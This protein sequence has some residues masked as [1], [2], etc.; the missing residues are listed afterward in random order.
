MV[1]RNARSYDFGKMTRRDA[2]SGGETEERRGS[3]EHRSLGRERRSSVGHSRRRTFPGRTK[4]YG[5]RR[6][7]RH[8][9]A[10]SSRTHGPGSGARTR[11]GALGRGGGRAARY[12]TAA[13]GTDGHAEVTVG[14]TL[15]AG[16][17]GTTSYRHGVQ[18]GQV[19]QLEVVT[20]TGERVLCSRTRNADLFDA[21]RAVAKDSSALLPRPGFGLRKAGRRIRQYELRYRDFDRFARDFERDHRR[22]PIRSS[23]GGNPGPR[24]GYPI[25]GAG[26]EYDDGDCED[27]EDARRVGVRRDRIHQGHG[28]RLDA[29]GSIQDGHSVGGCITPGGTGSCPGTPFERYVAQAWLDPRLGPASTGHLDRDLPD[30]NPGDRRPAL[31]ASEGRT[32]VLLLDPRSVRWPVR[33]RQTNWRED[34][35]KIDRTLVDLGAKGLSVR[36]RGLRTEGMGGTLRRRSF[37]MG[38]GWKKGV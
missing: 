14:G 15:S 10:Q 6:G 22:R 29:P 27:R 35:E 33:K 1:D 13:S 12:T 23:S 34:C 20:G 38:V 11:R 17:F 18:I 25:M 16:G 37:E 7:A 28:T 32:H 3:I 19:E 26:V 9:L 36:P 30:R 8:G 4:P 31:H 2:G 5:Q 24:P 21:V